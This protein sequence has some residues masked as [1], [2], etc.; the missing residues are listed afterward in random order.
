MAFRF[1]ATLPLEYRGMRSGTSKKTGNPWVSLICEDADASQVELSV[2]LD[3][4]G[5]VY[6]LG[7]VKG[8]KIVA[9]VVASASSD[10]NSYVQLRYLPEL[11]T[12]DGEVLS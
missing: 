2:P 3:M 10:G 8:D 12:D 5:E 9:H 1:N 6:S 7:L 4:Q 11:V